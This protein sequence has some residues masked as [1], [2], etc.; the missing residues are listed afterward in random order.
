LC[1]SRPVMPL[2]NTASSA[3]A[4]PKSVLNAALVDQRLQPLLV[5]ASSLRTGEIDNGRLTRCVARYGRDITIHIATR[6]ARE[7]TIRRACREHFSALGNPR[8]DPQA[9]AK[10]LLAQ[11]RQMLRG[12]GKAAVIPREVGE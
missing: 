9:D 10:S 5:P 1:S 11:L 6:S 4:S 7:V 3:I 8:L 12:L 2:A